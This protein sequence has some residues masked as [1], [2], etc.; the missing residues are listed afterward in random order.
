MYSKLLCDV[1]QGYKGD[2]CGV[3]A[4]GFGMTS[5]FSCSR[6]LGVQVKDIQSV[7]TG[8]LVLQAPIDKASLGG[9]YIFYCVALTAWCWFS[10]WTAV[11]DAEPQLPKA[12][13]TAA[14]TEASEC[15]A[16][17]SAVSVSSSAAAASKQARHSDS[18]AAAGGGGGDEAKTVDA[19]SVASVKEQACARCGAAPDERA[20]PLD[21]VKVSR[22]ADFADCLQTAC[23]LPACHI[24]A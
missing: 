14:P 18:A 22:F 2:L 11:E 4:H 5:P 23:K 13:R 20:D 6:C 10:V 7:A 9:L 21:V 16:T 15:G 19:D 24:L 3:C 8:Q 1:K 12:S 17:S